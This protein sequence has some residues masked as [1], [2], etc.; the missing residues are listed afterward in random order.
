MNFVEFVDKILNKEDND[1]LIAGDSLRVKN[2][3]NSNKPNCS[4]GKFINHYKNYSRQK[5]LVCSYKGCTEDNNLNG[6][7][8]Y[9]CESDNRKQYIIPLCDK[10]NNHTNKDCFKINKNTK[11]VSVSLRHSCKKL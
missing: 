4:C 11:L 7:H 9:I 3:Q 6:G 5:N 8:V 10:H 2:K 1:I